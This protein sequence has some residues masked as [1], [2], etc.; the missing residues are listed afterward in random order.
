M[1]KFSIENPTSYIQLSFFF[2]HQMA[3]EIM[4]SFRSS[5]WI[6]EKRWYVGYRLIPS[7]CHE[8]NEIY[9]I[10]HFCPTTVPFFDSD[11]SISSTAPLAN[12]KK[13]CFLLF[14]ILFPSIKLTN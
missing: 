5:F 10:P 3:E 6:R 4:E 14:Q 9:S 12:R 1:G 2:S 7:L 13:R 11:K 8:Y